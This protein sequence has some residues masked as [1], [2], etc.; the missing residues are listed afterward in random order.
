MLAVA[1]KICTW[2]TPRSSP[3]GRSL[4]KNE[5][6]QATTPAPNVVARNTESPANAHKPGPVDCGRKTR[7]KNTEAMA[8]S[9]A[10]SAALKASLASGN[11]RSANAVPEPIRRAAISPCGESRTSPKS[12]TVS[13][14][15][16]VWVS[17]RIST[18]A[19]ARSASRN[20]GTKY[21]H[22]APVISAGAEAARY[23]ATTRTTVAS[24]NVSTLTLRFGVI[25]EPTS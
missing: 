20:A 18:W 9:P 12:K 17:S 21:H 15:D 1:V 3:R 23:Q 14:S 6:T 4:S 8:A 24:A 10:K 25:T 7:C 16:R 2:K 19:S 11:R 5:M 22:V 13:L